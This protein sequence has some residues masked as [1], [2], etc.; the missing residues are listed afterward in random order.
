MSDPYMKVGWFDGEVSYLFLTEYSAT[1]SGGGWYKFC[2]EEGLSFDRPAEQV[3]SMVP[4][5]GSAGPPVKQMRAHLVRAG[6]SIM[7]NGAPRRV[8][9]TRMGPGCVTFELRGGASM[10][11]DADQMLEVRK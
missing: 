2:T 1:K 10:L 6:H 8:N 5:T 3:Q 4:A 9:G 11:F 7:L